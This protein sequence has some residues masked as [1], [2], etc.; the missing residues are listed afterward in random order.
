MDIPVKPTPGV[1][2]AATS[3][4]RPQPASEQ[5]APVK[6]APPVEAVQVVDLEGIQEAIAEQVSRFLQ[7]S[8]RNL[9][10]HVEGDSPVIIVRDGES[11]V[12]RRIPGE[13]ALEMLRLANAQSGTFVNLT[14]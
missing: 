13:T 7:T 14:A 6:A 3:P 4:K 9:E 1:P 12:I 5:P 10:F 8:A 2:A 11:R